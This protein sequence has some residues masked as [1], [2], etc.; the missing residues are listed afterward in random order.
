[1]YAALPPRANE[2][3]KTQQNEM[4][5]LSAT[6]FQ[7]F[8]LV[9][10]AF[11]KAVVNRTKVDSLVGSKDTFRLGTRVNDDGDVSRSLF[12]RSS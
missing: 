3:N 5:S 1:M 4:K 8:E 6:N 12:S 11:L 7:N 9:K 10:S 2:R